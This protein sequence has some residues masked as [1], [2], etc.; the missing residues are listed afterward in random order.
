MQ[1]ALNYERLARR[2]QNFLRLTG[3][4]VDKFNQI[5]KEIETAWEKQIVS[6]KKSP[7]GRTSNLKT[8]EDK[9]LALMVYYRTYITHEFIGY[10][11][12]LHNSNICRLFKLLEPMLA[13]KITITKDRSLTK[14]E[15]LKII[16][17]V[18]EQPTQRPSKKQKKYYSGKKKRHAVKTEIVVKDNGQI[19]SVSRMAP[20]RRHDFRMRKEGK[21]L[22]AFSSKYVDSGY[23]GLQK[24]T[25]GVTL[26]FR[27][28]KKHPLTHEQKMHN[29]AL[30][31]FRVKVEHKIRE[32]KIFKILKETY[33]NFQK[34]HNMRFNI[35]AGIVNLNHGF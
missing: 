14:E 15:V 23:Q 6:K 33:R 12:G 27:G 20:G 16:A 30:A 4:S 5:T 17:D 11:M 29:K 21:P 25:T 26:P 34:K 7:A 28:S 3:V 13:R 32:L 35:I 24:I 8:L 2:P 22:P 18:T 1:M 19:L 10:L 31:S 9:V